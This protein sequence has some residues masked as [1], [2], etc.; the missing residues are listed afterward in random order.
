[1]KKFVL[2]FLIVM[3][4]IF[5]SYSQ[6]SKNDSIKDKQY[7]YCE[8]VGTGKLFSTK[9]SIEVDFG[10]ETGYWTQYKDR[11]L[12]DENGKKVSFNSMVH[13]LNYMAKLGWKFEQ[14]YVITSPGNMGGG[15]NVYH[16][17][18][19][20]KA[21]TLDDAGTGLITKKDRE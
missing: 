18:L 8:I 9:V 15:Q 2:S 16:F 19:S 6:E 7:V 21:S 17:L 13:A 5:A 11:I 20:K 14:A 3:S 10:Q 4:C 1:M 12:V